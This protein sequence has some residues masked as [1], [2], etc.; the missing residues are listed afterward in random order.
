MRFSRSSGILLHPT[1]LP[2][3]HGIGDFG[4]A[5]YCFIDFLQAAGQKLWQVLP[6]NPTGYADSPFQAFSGNAGNPLL[7]SLDDL[8][9]R[10]VL[11]ESDLASRPPFPEDHVDFG[12]VIRFKLPLLRRAAENFFRSA[13]DSEREKYVAFLQQNRAWLDDFALFSAVKEAH[14]LVA[15]N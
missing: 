9:G 6:L 15:W 5:A 4:P 14:D 8:V 11:A 1:S 13:A 12:A 10:G 3:G 2:G 7:I